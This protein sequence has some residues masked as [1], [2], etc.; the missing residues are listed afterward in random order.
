MT[1]CV[2]ES[3][4][5]CLTK[6]EIDGE[7]RDIYLKAVTMC[8]CPEHAELKLVELPTIREIEQKVCQAT[9]DLLDWSTVESVPDDP[10]DPRKKLV[11]HL[12]E[13]VFGDDGLLSIISDLVKKQDT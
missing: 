6:S 9:M 1:T 4:S 10:S 11:E 5:S 3:L 12:A 7:F 2:V 13:H 8:K